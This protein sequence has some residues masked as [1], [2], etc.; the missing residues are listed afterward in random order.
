M[1]GHF[2]KKWG[3]NRHISI[4]YLALQSELRTISVDILPNLKKYNAI[5]LTD[6]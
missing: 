1:W 2:L 3:T 6:A 4:I 5:F